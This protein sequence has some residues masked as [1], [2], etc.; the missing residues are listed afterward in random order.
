MA[1]SF[2]YT[3]SCSRDIPV[4][5]QKVMTSQ[6][7]SVQISREIMKHFLVVVSTMLYM[8]EIGNQ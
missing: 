6:I 2:L 3:F 1:Y 8:V 4:F 5:V 7:V